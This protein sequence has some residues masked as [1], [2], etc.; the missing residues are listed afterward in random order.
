LFRGYGSDR[1]DVEDGWIPRYGTVSVEHIEDND[2][3]GLKFRVSEP[4][5]SCYRLFRS[6]FN[7][8]RLEWTMINGFPRNVQVRVRT[9]KGIR[10]VNYYFKKTPKSAKLK[11][12]SSIKETS[13]SRTLSITIPYREGTKR[14]E[15]RRDLRADLKLMG[16]EYFFLGSLSVYGNTTLLGMKLGSDRPD[17]PLT[18]FLDYHFS[19]L[20][21]RT[22]L[23]P[24]QLEILR[25][26][27]FLGNFCGQLKHFDGTL[28]NYMH[29]WLSFWQQYGL[30]PF[31]LFCGLYLGQYVLVGRDFVRATLRN[32]T[33]EF[34][35][36]RAWRRFGTRKRRTFRYDAL[37][38]ENPALLFTFLLATFNL[39]EIIF[40]RSYA[41]PYAWLSL[42][43]MP[44]YL[45]TFRSGKNRPGSS[46]ILT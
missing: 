4:K 3:S 27:W 21:P 39:I 7:P 35:K 36:I 43:M 20:N 28:G 38:I 19:Q 42:G 33:V 37:K 5:A 41:T 46:T 22:I 17:T 34:R 45:S 16:E 32:W 25:E 12:T 2:E 24:R 31:L 40:A 29:N 8:D 23:V 26:R 13:T 44:A 30:V 6:G 18:R 9:D 10:S 1:I 11:T 14:L 15:F